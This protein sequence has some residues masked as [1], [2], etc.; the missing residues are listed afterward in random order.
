VSTNIHIVFSKPPD[1][2]SDEAFNRWYDPHLDE[3]L[4]VP[5]FVS[6]QRYRM[7]AMVQKPGTSVPYGFLSLYELEGDVDTIMAELDEE[8]AS[9]RM[10]LP[11]WFPEISFASWNCYALGEKAVARS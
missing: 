11:E 5:G 2:I 6:A 7:E 3:I 10:N 1:R 4:V 9:G 8:A